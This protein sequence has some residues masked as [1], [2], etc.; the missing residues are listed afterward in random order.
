MSGRTVGHR[1]L[2]QAAAAA[3][4]YASSAV[5]ERQLWWVAGELARAL[6]HPDFPVDADAPVEDLFEREATTAYLDLGAAGELRVRATDTKPGTENLHTTRMRRTVLG[7][8]AEQL[9]VEAD[10]PRKPPRPPA[11]EPVAPRP[12]ELLRERLTD[13]QERTLG[14]EST[15]RLR[16]LAIGGM[17]ADTGARSGELVDQ[18]LNDL[19]PGL[20]A[21][22]VRRRPQGS[23]SEGH[24][25]VDAVPLQRPSS[26][27]VAAWLRERHR[28]IAPAAD[29][30]RDRTRSAPLTGSAWALWVSIRSNH[31][32]IHADGT[33]APRPAGTPLGA[34]GLAYAWN[35]AV[36]ETNLALQGE[37]GWTPLP[38]RMDQLRRG[39]QPAGFLAPSA[40]PLQP[41]AERAVELLDHLA[42]HGRALAAVLAQADV[43]GTALR[44]CRRHVR[45]ALDWVWF[46]GIE[47]RSA[48][49]TLNEAGLYGSDLAQAGWHPALLQALDL[50]NR[51]GRN[52]KPAEAA[53]P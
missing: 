21:A 10:L 41:D 33:A 2:D 37:P 20:T 12:R 40:P 13:L 43:D 19:H 28:I 15:V 7:L 11:K 27:A 46:E 49:R 18:D 52:P 3:A 36:A 24:T 50:A 30:T 45:R 4:K 34:R 42:E 47:H 39:V 22:R 44:R 17:V 25:R 14:G 8:L 38:D 48:L 23:T 31:G 51:Y 1:G 16:M 29:D 26:T 5:R 35:S 53:Q 9:G 32:E 6:Q